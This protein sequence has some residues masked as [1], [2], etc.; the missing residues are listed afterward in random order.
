M[1]VAQVLLSAGVDPNMSNPDG[2]T[3]LHA[4]ASEGHTQVT[5]P[6]LLICIK[7]TPN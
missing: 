7:Y 2:E 6:L 4:A 3:P 1:Q 5:R